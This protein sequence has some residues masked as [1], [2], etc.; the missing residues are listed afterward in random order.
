MRRVLKW[1]GII[2]GVLLGLVVLAIIAIFVISSLRINRSYDVEVAAVAIPDDSEALARGEHLARAIAPCTACHGDDLGGYLMIDEPDFIKLYGP[3]LT[4][5]QGGVGAFYSD[6]DW[7]RAVRHGVDPEGR[8]LLVMPSHHFQYMSDEDLGAVLAYVNS[9]PPVDNETPDANVGPFGRLFTL[10]APGFVLPASGID[11]EAV[12]PLT[13]AEGVTV[14]YGQYLV[15]MGTC[16]DCHGEELNG[17]ADGAEDGSPSANLTPAG[18]L[19]QWTEEDFIQVLRTGKHPS[20]RDLK[21]PMREVAVDYFGHQTD[22][23]LT[24]IFTYLQSLPP[25]ENGY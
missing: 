13:P 17:Q 5:G 23:E 2:L 11:Q 10:I 7:V 18:E 9:V 16:A 8:G 21:E 3:N 12:S 19:G 15:E 25:T 20:G 4:S 6:E 1:I 24:A 22:D 14:E